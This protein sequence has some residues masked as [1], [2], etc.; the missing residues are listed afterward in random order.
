VFGIA[1][2][3]LSFVFLLPL[4]AHALIQANCPVWL[5][6][7]VSVI[8][9]LLESCLI[10]LLFYFA[11]MLPMFQDVLFDCTL[12]AAGLERMFETRVPVSTMV[13]CCRGISS[14]LVMVWFL[15]LTQVFLLILT[16][17][18]NLIPI[19]GTVMACYIN[20]WLTW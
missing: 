15:I 11:I 5:A 19:V 18:L 1:S 6:W 16:A 13:V 17:P 20:G 4:Q 2:L 9:V 3:V 14:G 12:R 7:L 8:F 10:D